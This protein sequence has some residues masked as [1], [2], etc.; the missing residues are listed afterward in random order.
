MPSAPAEAALPFRLQLKDPD[1]DA[2]KAAAQALFAR[3]GPEAGALLRVCLQDPD[4][5]VRLYAAQALEVVSKRHQKLLRSLREA[6]TEA[7]VD[8]ALRRGIADALMSYAEE[9]MDAG[10]LRR[11]AYE[12]ALFHLSAALWKTPQAPDLL[13]RKG[14]ALVKLRRFAQARE[15]LELLRPADREYPMARFHLAEAALGEGRV[16]AARAE[17]RRLKDAALPATLKQ[18][19]AFWAEEPT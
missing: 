9:G 7:P 15:T 18:A 8:I 10:E 19:V 11:H 1:P 13:L 17:C 12:E 3:G 4:E 5:R 6:L 2:R 14:A 16:D